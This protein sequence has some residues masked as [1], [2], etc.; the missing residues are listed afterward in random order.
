MAE[1]KDWD[2]LDLESERPA[3]GKPPPIPGE[4]KRGG[5]ALRLGWLLALF[6]GAAGAALGGVALDG[7]GEI[8]AQLTHAR[9]ESAQLR[10]RLFVTEDN[11]TLEKKARVAEAAKSAQLEEEVQQKGAEKQTDSQLIDE[12]KAKLDEKD[13]DVSAEGRHIA[14]NFVDEILFP[15]GEAELSA[16]GKEVLGKVGAVLK[17]L[18]DQQILVGG[19]TDDRPIHNE[20]F[21][22]NWE[23]SAARAVNVARYLVETVGVDPH[24]VVAAGYSEYHPRGTVRRQNRR[25]ELLLTPTVEVKR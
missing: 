12:L 5:R 13:G 23:L 6:F 15:S 16:H 25:I 19:H 14:V 24:R 10:R 21:P 20:K 3:A 7:R 18:T 11:L 1:G 17:G 2:E 4:K 22:S 8:E 9:D